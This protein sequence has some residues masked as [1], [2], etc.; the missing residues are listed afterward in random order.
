MTEGESWNQVGE[1][2]AGIVDIAMQYGSKGLDM[3]FMHEEQFA[4]NI[5]VW[6]TILMFHQPSSWFELD[7]L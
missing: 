5:K 2:L 3:H 1:A 4:E 6:G 7:S